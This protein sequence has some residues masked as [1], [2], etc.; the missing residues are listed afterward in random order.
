[1][2]SAC[3]CP[4][5]GPRPTASASAGVLI[6]L[7]IILLHADPSKGKRRTG[8]QGLEIFTKPSR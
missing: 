4:R 3:G 6:G 2:L 8:I 1:M 7:Q 5:A